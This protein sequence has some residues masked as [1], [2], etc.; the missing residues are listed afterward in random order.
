MAFEPFRCIERFSSNNGKK[1]VP[2]KLVLSE[3]TAT[4]LVWGGAQRRSQRLDS[5]G[6]KQGEDLF[7]CA[8]HSVAKKAR[9]KT[10]KRGGK[11]S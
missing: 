11:L 5:H 4:T 7:R 6:E 8:P 9:E 2:V 1:V 3:F 10:K